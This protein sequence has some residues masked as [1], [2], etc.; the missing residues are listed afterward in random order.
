MMS[1]FRIR[2]GGATTTTSDSAVADEKSKGSKGSKGKGKADT[3]TNNNTNSNNDS[4]DGLALPS[5]TTVV[6]TT[7]NK[8]VKGSKETV[9]RSTDN[10][11]NGEGTDVPADAVVASSSHLSSVVSVD[12]SSI[13]TSPSFAMSAMGGDQSLDPY[14][15]TS[16]TKKKKK[17]KKSKLEATAAKNTSSSSKKFKVNISKILSDNVD[18]LR[19]ELEKT[20]TNHFQLGREFEVLTMERM[21]LESQVES[22]EQTIDSLRRELLSVKDSNCDNNT[23]KDSAV[24]LAALAQSKEFERIRQERDKYRRVNKELRSS[25]AKLEEQVTILSDEVT[26]KESADVA[27][28]CIL[29][30]RERD[31]TLAVEAELDDAKDEI[32]LLRLGASDLQQALDDN[33][34]LEKEVV[35]LRQDLEDCAAEYEEEIAALEG[36]NARLKEVN[37]QQSKEIRFLK[38]ESPE[39]SSKHGDSVTSATA[40]LSSSIVAGFLDNEEL[41]DSSF[42]ETSV[43]SN[44]VMARSIETLKSQNEILQQETMRLTAVEE[45]LRERNAI[46]L[47]AYSRLENNMQNVVTNADKKELKLIETIREQKASLDFVY[48]DLV[49]ANNDIRA[50]EAKIAKLE[51]EKVENEA[52]ERFDEEKNDPFIE[53][54]STE[55]ALGY[56]DHLNIVGANTSTARHSETRIVHSIVQPQSS[57]N[58][59]G[60]DIVSQHDML[61]SIMKTKKPDKQ[62]SWS[63]VGSVISSVT[64]T[65]TESES[66]LPLNYSMDYC[67]Y[68]QE[69]CTSL[70]QENLKLKS[71]LVRL[72]SYHKGTVYQHEL[73]IRELRA[74]NEAQMRK[75]LTN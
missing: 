24:Q 4:T 23:D 21:E 42:H 45:A 13:S 52:Q 25:V 62:A 67:R 72:Q 66:N 28:Q 74:A 6:S 59:A 2:R 57:D 33:K 69:R 46:Q 18:E 65:I 47:A 1:S 44:D 37:D 49:K 53:K 68:T 60:T 58:E 17:K 30:R 70:E 29:L 19:Q 32:R 48:K 20:Q 50:L 75:Q 22:Q 14:V 9:F 10:Q 55:T 43:R 61:A 34:E 40:S 41:S 71:N 63:W 5:S 3:V 7:N 11:T 12:E 36:V 64:T 39:K 26:D 35:M 8:K 38:R 16:T 54:R 15:E 31:R 27:D 51:A 73:T 56:S